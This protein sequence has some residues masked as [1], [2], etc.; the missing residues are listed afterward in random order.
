MSRRFLVIACLLSVANGR[1]A[2][3]APR[4]TTW[5]F[6]ALDRIG[7]LPVKVEGNPKVIE[8]LLGKAIQFD[9]VDDSICGI[10]SRP[11]MTERCFAA[12]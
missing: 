10:T 2:Q 4:Q 1:A 6:D 8:T 9:G 12:T 5:T 7:G 3:N 11:L